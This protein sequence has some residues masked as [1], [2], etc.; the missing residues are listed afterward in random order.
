MLRVVP[1]PPYEIDFEDVKLAPHKRED[2][3]LVGAPPSWWVGAKLKWEVRER[4]GSQ[5]LAKTLDRPLFQRT[6]TFMATRRCPGYTMQADILTDGNRRIMSSAGLINQR[7]LILLK[8]NHQAIE[9]SSN[10]ELFKK[11]VKFK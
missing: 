9:V 4:D 5:V 3:V 11:S 8:G 10:M 6:L 1:D 7:Y 2:G